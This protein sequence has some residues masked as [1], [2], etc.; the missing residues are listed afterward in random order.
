MITLT[1]LKSKLHRLSVTDTCLD[2]EGSVTLDPDLMLAADIAEY[3]QVHIWDVNNGS[4]VITYALKG[5]KGTGMVQ[6]NGAGARLIDPGDKV[7]IATFQQ[8]DKTH[9]KYHK[10]T[11]VLIKNNNNKEFSIQD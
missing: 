6:V 5:E 3:E 4:R 1:V 11:I 8:L 2:Y 10:P 9:V 7:I